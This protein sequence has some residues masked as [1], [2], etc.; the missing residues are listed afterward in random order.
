MNVISKIEELLCLFWSFVVMAVLLECVHR[1]I[2]TLTQFVLLFLVWG[3]YMSLSLLITFLWASQFEYE[4]KKE[5]L[6]W[7]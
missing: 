4:E 1:H 6:K 2:L 7:D 5:K 3:L